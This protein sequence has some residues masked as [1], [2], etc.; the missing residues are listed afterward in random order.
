[1]IDLLSLGVTD[2]IQLVVFSTTLR[3]FTYIAKPSFFNIS[4]NLHD[5][6]ITYV[7]TTTF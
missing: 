3:N 1:M 6:E 7:S 2:E 5:N 4:Y